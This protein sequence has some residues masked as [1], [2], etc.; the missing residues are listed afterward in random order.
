MRTLTPDIIDLYNGL[1]DA[2]E[3]I[4]IEGMTGLA[5]KSGIDVA[6]DRISIMFFKQDARHHVKI[7]TE[8]T[9]KI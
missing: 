5:M 2:R 6:L 1:I 4:K 3:A 7:E 8:K 9:E